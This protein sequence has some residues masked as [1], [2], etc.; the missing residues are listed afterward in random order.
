M[1][2]IEHIS[3]DPLTGVTCCLEWL[4]DRRFRIVH[5]ADTQ[6]PSIAKVLDRNAAMRS[7]AGYK[8]QGIKQSWMHAAEIPV[9]VQMKWLSE[10]IDLMNPDHWP[11]VKAKLNDPEY[12]YLKTIE[13]QV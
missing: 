1:S 3:Y 2:I 11:R 9:A 8:K 10:G 6:D 12:A 7:D 5:H 4:D 13:G